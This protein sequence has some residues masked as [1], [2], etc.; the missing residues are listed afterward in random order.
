[1]R[2]I[3]VFFGFAL[4]INGKGFSQSDTIDLQEVKV[5][6][7]RLNQTVA[8]SGRSITVLLPE[9]IEA[10]P[11]TSV[12]DLLKHVAGLDIKSRGLFGVQSDISSRGSTFSQVLI[13][14]DGM[15]LNDPITAHFNNAIPVPLSEL[16]RVEIIRGPA[17]ALYGADAVGGVINFITKTFD[18]KHSDRGFHTEGQF[19]AGEEKLMSAETNFNYSSEKFRISAG[20]QNTSSEGQLLEAGNR[21][22]F[23]IRQ[24][25]LSGGADLGNGWFAA[26]RTGYDFRNFDAKYFY[27]ASPSDQAREQIKGWWNQARLSKTKNN[28]SST[29]NINYNT[30]Q[31]S[32]LFMPSSAA[33]IHTSNLL[34]IQF[35]ESYR[36]SNELEISAGIQSDWRGIESTDRGNH[37][38]YHAAMYGTVFYMPLTN[39]GLT[40]SLRTDYDENYGTEILP[41]INATWGFEYFLVRAAMGR[42]IRAAD[43]TERYISRN[44]PGMLT[45][46]RNLGNPTLKAETSWSYE[47]GIDAYPLPGLIFR[48]TAFIRKSENLIDYIYTYGKDIDQNEK[49]SPDAEYFYAQNIQDLTTKGIETELIFRKNWNQYGSNVS[50]GHVYLESNNPTGQISKYISSHAKHILTAN[51]SVRNKRFMLSVNGLY[52]VRPSDEAKSINSSLSRNYFVLNAKTEFALKPGKIFLNL[53]AQNLLDLTYYDFLGVQ[54]PRRWILA[55][56][57]WSL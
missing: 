11:I 17:S 42:G 26:A 28:H 18:T 20:L 8:E 22:D 44:I 7:T 43:Y 16:S 24:F 12:D 38:D 6:S 55:G 34:N 30:T 47:T 31:D 50:V 29:L 39:V 23:L 51:A 19:L 48:T 21:N 33:N 9:Q 25:T 1:M 54:L 27:T 15:R 56:V 13:L 49:L 3:V 46:G 41:Q 14:L 32:F 53:Q 57:R 36:I 5:Y 40:G 4:F 52:K 35:N 45:A 10:L 2:G 37:S